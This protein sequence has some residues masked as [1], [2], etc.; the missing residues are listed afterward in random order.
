MV[1][2]I[3]KIE[4]RGMYYLFDP[5]VSL[6]EKL[7]IILQMAIATSDKQKTIVIAKKLLDFF[8]STYFSLDEASKENGEEKTVHDFIIEL[9]KEAEEFAKKLIPFPKTVEERLDF[10]FE[11]YRYILREIS[12]AM[13]KIRAQNVIVKW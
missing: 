12:R 9:E 2:E 8:M 1:K 10:E 4:E 7:D 3:E 5:D 6:H 13:K 11:K